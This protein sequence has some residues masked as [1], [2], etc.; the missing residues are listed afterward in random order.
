MI[1]NRKKF[2]QTL[3]FASL[4]TFALK[5]SKLF[6][7]DETKSISSGSLST[8]QTVLILG[9]GL[10]GLYSAYLLKKKGIR[11]KLIEASS[12]L[13]GRI[14]SVQNP[15]TGEAFD[16]GG[17]WIGDYHGLTRKLVAN[18]GLSLIRPEWTQSQSLWNPN[19]FSEKSKENLE[20]LIN[21]QSTIATNQKE[22]LDKV[23]LFRY[24]R[25]QGF[26]DSELEDLDRVVKTY[27]GESSRNI[28]SHFLLASMESKKSLFQN[29]YKVEGGAQKIIAAL[30]ATLDPSDVNLGDLAT[31]VIQN[32][33][34]ITIELSS[35]KSYQG[36]FLI[37][38][39]PAPAVTEIKWEPSLPR[40]KIFSLL[41][42]GYGRIHKEIVE[43]QT[44]ISN[45]EPGTGIIDWILPLKKNKA[46]I[47]CTEGR[48]IALE[49]SGSEIRQNL[50]QK[51]L[52]NTSILSYPT[53]NESR[54]GFGTGAVSNYSPSTISVKEELLQSI[55]NIHFAGEHLGD[56]PGTMEAA[57]S[58]ATFAV[59]KLGI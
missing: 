3:G 38:T 53:I 12:R 15:I 27:Y 57:I 36:K 28:S 58:S 55:G 24:L 10:A 54:L 18:L 45:P 32:K 13:G 47:V 48:A 8:Q 5:G 21:L 35:G 59:Q 44:P 2:L 7:Q 52:L 56:T 16:L 19:L 46:T 42:V 50:I 43:L 9:G 4:A 20:K 23:S 39:L 30:V 22:G 40:E 6:S 51:S 26:T 31:K 11:V 29:L 25:Y 34:G 33:S 37:C 49:R 17:E 14:F 41:R 1:V